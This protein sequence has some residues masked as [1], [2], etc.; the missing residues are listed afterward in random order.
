MLRLSGLLLLGTLAFAE[1]RIENSIEWSV[2]D[3]D[4][5]VRGR[6]VAIGAAATDKDTIW[7]RGR[8]RLQELDT[9]LSTF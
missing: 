8:R 6:I 5:I 2:V 9:I 7:Q 1:L 4:L 3:S